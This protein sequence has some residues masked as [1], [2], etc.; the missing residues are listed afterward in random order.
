MMIWRKQIEAEQVVTHVIA[1]RSELSLD[2]HYYQFE[3]SWNPLCDGTSWVM[4][5]KLLWVL[6]WIVSQCKIWQFVAYLRV[7]LIFWI[8]GFM[9]N[10]IWVLIPVTSYNSFACLIHSAH[11]TRLHS[12]WSL[13]SFSR[14]WRLQ[15]SLVWIR[16]NKNTRNA[17]VVYSRLSMEWTNF[18]AT[19][20]DSIAWIFRDLL[21]FALTS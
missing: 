15:K 1:Q 17:T 6:C 3:H 13:L 7:Y 18:A 2:S 20:K 8:I 12:R 4:V 11:L 16:L 5:Y 14:S 10:S 21:I 9:V 19:V